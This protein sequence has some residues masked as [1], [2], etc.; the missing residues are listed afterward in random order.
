MIKKGGGGTQ[1]TKE[2]G[3]NVYFTIQNSTTAITGGG[4][5]SEIN[6]E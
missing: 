1:K 4:E 5:M 2:L 6:S 3:P